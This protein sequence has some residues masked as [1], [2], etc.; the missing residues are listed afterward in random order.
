MNDLEIFLRLSFAGLSI[1]LTGISLASYAKVWEGKLALASLGFCLFAVEGSLLALGVFLPA[2]EALN[3]M[4]L[5]VGVVLVAL[6]FF[7]LSI[8]KR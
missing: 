2:V 4:M 1:I 7:Y 8:L 6:I 3:S 5:L